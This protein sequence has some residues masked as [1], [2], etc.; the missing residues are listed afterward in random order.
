MRGF[1]LLVL[2]SISIVPAAAWAA[3]PTIGIG[4]FGGA[5]IPIVQDDV[6]RG[7]MFGI[8]APVTIIKI[9]SLEPYF[10]SSSLGDGE[11]SIGG[12]TYTRDGFKQT[13]FGINAMLGSL[14]GTARFRIYPYVGIGSNKLT[15]QGSDDISEVGYNFGLGVGI[16]PAARFALQLRGELDMV[17]TGD[18]S[19]KFANG[20]LGVSYDVWPRP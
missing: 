9:F 12:V 3:K 16:S 20:T 11:Q 13:A 8:R 6:K 10:A 17:K 14:S 19:R 5:S 18:T 1:T 4:G 15:R 2:V 7:A